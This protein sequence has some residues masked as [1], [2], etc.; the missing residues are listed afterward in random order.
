MISW[1]SRSFVGTTESFCMMP[2]TR[3]RQQFPGSAWMRSDPLQGGWMLTKSTLACLVAPR[4]LQ[5][6]GLANNVTSAGVFGAV[7]PGLLGL[8]QQAVDFL[9][10]GLRIVI[11]P[12][13]DG[14]HP[15]T[16]G[17]QAGNG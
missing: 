9:E 8:V 10:E 12:G 15:Q 4:N 7:A 16:D 3:F 14:G 11:L 17:E 6:A 1:V 13:N 5:C 2:Q